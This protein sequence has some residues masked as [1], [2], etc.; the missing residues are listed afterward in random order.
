MQVIMATVGTDGD[1][2][3][4]V[5][6][7]MQLR[8]RGHRVTLAA[9][10]TYRELA[11]LPDLEFCSLVTTDEGNAMLTETERDLAVRANSS[12]ADV[13][14]PG[15]MKAHGISTHPTPGRESV[16]AWK[17]PV[18]TAQLSISGR[19]EHAHPEC[20]NGV[21]WA[22]EVRRGTTTEKLASG[23]LDQAKGT[24]LGPFEKVRIEADHVVALSIGPRDSNHACDL[25]AVQL[26]LSDGDNTWDLAK[27]V[28][29]NI[30]LGNPHGAWHFLSHDWP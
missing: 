10:E 27:D 8:Q 25:T 16:I 21:T 15:I 26:T 12:D 24:P 23:V 19:V 28:S 13:R 11:C 20:G 29:P 2:F 30:L 14:F 18:T 1:I 17:S 4:H 3:P 6:I 9:R 22:L 5:A 7:G